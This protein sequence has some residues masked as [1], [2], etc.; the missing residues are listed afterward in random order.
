[1]CLFCK[2][3]VELVY[4]NRFL[5]GDVYV[6]P[7]RHL[8][9]PVSTMVFKYTKGKRVRYEIKQF[10]DLI[11][12]AIFDGEKGSNR[13][14]QIAANTEKRKAE[15]FIERMKVNGNRIVED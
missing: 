14:I 10:Y 8:G 1:M 13:L 7:D 5:V 12:G 15:M 4:E 2:K 11:P 3:K 9:V 6:Y